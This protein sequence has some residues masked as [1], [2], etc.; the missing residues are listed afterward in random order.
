[1]EALK[2]VAEGIK[3]ISDSEIAE[4]NEH[5]KGKYKIVPDVPNCPQGFVWSDQHGKCVAD[6]G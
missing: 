1:M 5:L 2:E 6:V 3:L 4:L